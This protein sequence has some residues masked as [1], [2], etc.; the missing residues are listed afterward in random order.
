[1]KE[2]QRLKIHSKLSVW[3]RKNLHGGQRQESHGPLWINH[4]PKEVTQATNTL[5]RQVV[6]S[7]EQMSIL[8]PQTWLSSDEVDAAC[9]YIALTFPNIA[10]F[11]S[12][13][14]HQT[15]HQGRCG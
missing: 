9:F 14:Y 3:K 6:I 11:Q 8:H 10:R 15:L 1:M 12:C 4:L 5:L 2:I 7:R 13:P